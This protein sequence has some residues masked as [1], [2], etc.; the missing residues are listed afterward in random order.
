MSVR[1]DKVRNDARSHTVNTVQQPE[2]QRT[3]TPTGTAGRMEEVDQMTA[4]GTAA[5]W[6]PAGRTRHQRQQDTLCEVC[7]YV[8]FLIVLLLFFLCG[9]PI[10]VNFV[11]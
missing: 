5:T 9:C 6:T 4:T 11:G 10:N 7:M 8:C 2:H 3:R 1:S